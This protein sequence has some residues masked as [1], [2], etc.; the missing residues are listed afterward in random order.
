[1]KIDTQTRYSLKEGESISVT[2]YDGL[3]MDGICIHR[4]GFA[5]EMPIE[6]AESLCKEFAKKIEGMKKRI[7]KRADMEG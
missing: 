5:I 7:K 2:C 4:R 6:L 1:M 3:G